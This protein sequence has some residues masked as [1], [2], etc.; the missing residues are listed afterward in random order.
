[1]G[2]YGGLC[3]DFERGG[4]DNVSWAYDR[5]HDKASLSRSGCATPANGESFLSGVEYVPMVWGK[6]ALHNVSQMNTTF[7]RGARYIFSFNEPDH[8]G[9]SYLPPA[10]G[11][12]RWPDMVALASL[13]NLTLVAPCVSN[14]ESGEW[15]LAAWHAACRNS[16]GAPC[17]HDHSCL[18]TYFEPADEGA[19]FDSLA[20]MH[21][22]YARPIWLNEFACPPY[23]QCSAA[24]QL[25]FARAVVPRLEALP[26]LFRYAWF[27]ARAAGNESLLADGGNAT[28]VARTPLGDFYNSA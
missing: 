14:F 3:A 26:Y 7:I 16:T 5:G 11:A 21:A 10:E 24:A 20:R 19:L 23:K 18:H 22:A 4:L 28:N 8:S 12:A 6:F 15:W 27:E 25:A 9:S 13:F 17:A 2:Y 1:V